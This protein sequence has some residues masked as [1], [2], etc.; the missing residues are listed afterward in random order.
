MMGTPGPRPGGAMR[1]DALADVCSQH[2]ARS[3]LPGAPVGVRGPRADSPSP[4]VWGCDLLQ[5]AA[6]P[7]WPGGQAGEAACAEMMEK[8]EL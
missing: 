1:C 6:D 4:G 7:S 2:L 3:R 5:S 8:I